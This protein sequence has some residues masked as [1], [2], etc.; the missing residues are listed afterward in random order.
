[1]ILSNDVKRLLNL[2]NESMAPDLAKSSS[3]SYYLYSLFNLNN[4]PTHLWFPKRAIFL[5]FTYFRDLREGFG[6]EREDQLV[7]IQ[8][9]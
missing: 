7:L 5:Q 8:G 1:M 6:F 9:T 3:D 4:A 2:Q